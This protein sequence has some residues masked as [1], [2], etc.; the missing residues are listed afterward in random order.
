MR[1]ERTGWPFGHA[2]LIAMVAGCG[3]FVGAPRLTTACDHD[4]DSDSDDD[5]DDD[6]DW[7]NGGKA[8]SERVGY[9]LSLAQLALLEPLVISLW[10]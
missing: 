4:E 9:P 7:G 1:C 5:N 6:N 8:T 10:G 2:P 3:L